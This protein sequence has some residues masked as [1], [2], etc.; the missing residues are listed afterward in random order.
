M[1]A[2]DDFGRAGEDRA[3]H[4]FESTGFTIIDR[5]WRCRAGEIDLVALSRD[6]IVVVEVKARTSEAFGHPFEALSAAKRARMW[7][8]GVAWI[9]EHRD[10]VQGR[11]LRFAALGLI[12]P[13]PA[14][15]Q[16]ELLPDLDVR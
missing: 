15:A 10:L 14:T 5:N 9:A 11:R 7:R 12:G 8:V 3:A 2:K 6:E 16:L 13:D 1:A 4:H